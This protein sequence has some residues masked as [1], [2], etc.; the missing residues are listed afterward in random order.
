MACKRARNTE[1]SSVQ[2]GSTDTSSL[3][4]G[5]TT[6]A[7]PD[8]KLEFNRLM[9]NP[10]CKERGFFPSPGDGD[11]VEMIEKMGW[12]S[13]CEAPE[14][15]SLG[16]VREFYANAKKEKNGFT[17]VRGMTVDYHAEAIRKVIGQKAKP[18]NAEN[19][20]HKTRDAINLDEIVLELCVPGRVWKWRAGTEE[21][22]SFPAG[23]MNRYARA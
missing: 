8:A 17:V 7:T 13:I 14:A 9:G 4:F 19:W 18:L 22:P 11:L 12:E 15:V 10:I 21:P 23:A 5:K 20:V 2:A 3:G 1:S 6:F 16:I